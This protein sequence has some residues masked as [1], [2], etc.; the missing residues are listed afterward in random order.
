MRGIKRVI[1]TRCSE[2][3]E[4]RRLSEKKPVAYFL[5]LLIKDRLRT[6]WKVRVSRS[7]RCPPID[8]V[9]VLQLLVAG[10][11]ARMYNGRNCIWNDKST[12][13]VQYV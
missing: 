6:V 3:K 11:T 7:R 12:R 10:F 13:A 2:E 9:Y 8:S 4:D 1:E 5:F